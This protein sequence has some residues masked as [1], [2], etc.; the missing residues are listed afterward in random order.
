MLAAIIAAVKA[1]APALGERVYAG[2]AP[3]GTG[4]PYAVA[5]DLNQAWRHR[6]RGKH[7]AAQVQVS[8]F[9]TSSE[10][11]R[12]LAEAIEDAL[13]AADL[14]LTGTARVGV[15]RPRLVSTLAVVERPVANTAAAEAVFH[16]AITFSMVIH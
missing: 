3:H 1:A 6:S 11:C 8:V 12:A 2:Y 10:Q 14:D 16:R 15:G 7:A 9:A 4:H 5:F 13:P